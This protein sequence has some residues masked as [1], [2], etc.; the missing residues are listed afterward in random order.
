M[1]KQNNFINLFFIF[2]MLFMN[3]FILPAYAWE[4]EVAP[5]LWNIHMKG[6]VKVNTTPADIDRTD[7]N[8]M[9]F[10]Q[11][12]HNNL[13][14]FVHFTYSFATENES[15]GLFDAQIKNK[16]GI[17]TSGLI[18]DVYKHP[19]SC[20]KYTCNFTL[21]PYLAGR[22]TIKNTDVVVSGFGQK[23]YTYQDENWLDP[24]IGMKL[25]WENQ[26]NWLF[27]LSGDVGGRNTNSRYSYNVF[28]LIGYKPL[29]FRNHGTL[30]FGYAVLDQHYDRQRVNNSFKWDIRLSGPL[31]GFSIYV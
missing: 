25:K 21:S 12:K 28:G 10:I 8:N 29:M 4:L 5:F 9:A 14:A 3:F 1:V 31:V 23:Y 20:F 6:S 22:Y 18:Y 27:V 13:G 7:W 2:L 16:Y 15:Y 17:F 19:I 11:L 26:Y 24:V 30:Y